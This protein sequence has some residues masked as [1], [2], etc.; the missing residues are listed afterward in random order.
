MGVDRVIAFLCVSVLMLGGTFVLLE[1]VAQ[2]F[3]WRA[4]FRVVLERK[5]NEECF[6]VER[7]ILWWPVWRRLDGHGGGGPYD[8]VEIAVDRMRQLQAQ[9]DYDCARLLKREVITGREVKP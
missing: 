2:I 7:K 5:L 4:E 6:R 9:N 8:S 3:S 1:M